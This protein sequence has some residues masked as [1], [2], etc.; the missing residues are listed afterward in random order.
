MILFYCLYFSVYHKNQEI[1][2]KIIEMINKMKKLMGLSSEQQNI[3]AANA[4][5]KGQPKQQLQKKLSG[6]RFDATDRTE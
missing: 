2:D 5:K 3:I 4:H 6:Q 1:L